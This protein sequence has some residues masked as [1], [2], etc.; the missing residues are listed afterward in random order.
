MKYEQPLIS[1]TIMNTYRKHICIICES[2][3]WLGHFMDGRA[4]IYCKNFFCCD[5]CYDYHIK[6]GAHI[7]NGYFDDGE[8]DDW[9]TKMRRFSEFRARMKALGVPNA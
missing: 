7:D 5:R 3:A 9:L 4:C 6:Y 8:V 2:E 1:E